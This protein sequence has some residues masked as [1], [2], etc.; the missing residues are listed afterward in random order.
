MI[1]PKYP[2]E[3]KLLPESHTQIMKELVGDDTPRLRVLVVLWV[4]SI[5]VTVLGT[6]AAVVQ[7]LRG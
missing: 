6:I 7:W 1:K 5:G 3:R 4:I 2:S